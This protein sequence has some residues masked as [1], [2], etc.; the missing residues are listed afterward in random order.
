M[1]KLI[2]ST[3][4]ISAVVLGIYTDKGE[5][6]GIFDFLFHPNKI[7]TEKSLSEHKAYLDTLRKPTIRI[8][9]S[10]HSGLSKIGGLPIANAALKWPVWKGKPLAFLAQINLGELPRSNTSQSLSKSGLLYFFYDQEQNTW[11]F[12]PNDRGSWAVE[13]VSDVGN[14]QPLT[15]P[16]GLQ[17]K[18]IY[19]EKFIQ[20][21]NVLTYPDWQDE[22]IEKL[23]LT[24]SQIDEYFELESSVYLGQPAHQLFG[25]A[26]PIQS[27]DMDLESQLV[28]NGLYCGDA[29]GYN[30]PQAKTLSSGRED[31]VLLLQLD[32]DDDADMMWGDAGMLYFWIRKQD[33]AN[34]EFSNVWMI[35][36]CS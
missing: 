7:Q 15:P 17:K 20:F 30:D 36:Q 14:L 8:E 9:K 18:A 22:R 5:P 31:W 32:S 12:D 11:G 21:S 29:S 3:A 2:I 1:N 25:Y 33:L 6:M 10:H 27:N 35:L 28:S 16:A 23:D 26:N 19:K 13:Y 4:L 24:D 34:R